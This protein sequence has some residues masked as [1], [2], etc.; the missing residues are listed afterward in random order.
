MTI[1]HA[2]DAALRESRDAPPPRE[3]A[4][5]HPGVRPS[6][7]PARGS[8]GARSSRPIKVVLLVLVIVEIVATGVLLGVG[9]VPAA[10]ATIVAAAITWGLLNLLG[11]R[12]GRTV[13]GAV[14][15]E[16]ATPLR[17]ARI[18]LGIAVGTFMLALVLAAVL[19]GWRIV[20]FAAL[21]FFLMFLF[22]GAPAWLAAT[23]EAA[24]EEL[25]ASGEAESPAP[26]R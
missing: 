9:A 4:P 20:G 11:I 3:S 23:Q 15:A 12:D 18:V 19:A 14:T 16:H 6:R 22:M 2:H 26:I 7:P 25:E 21:G 17:P 5:R 8:D 10:I 13:G 24:Q 1:E